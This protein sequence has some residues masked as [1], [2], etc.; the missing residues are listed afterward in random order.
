MNKILKE[1]SMFIFS[2]VE[3]ILVFRFILK[4]LGA[5]SNSSFVEFIYQN[6]QPLLSPFL[7]A[8]PSPSVRGRFILEFTTLFAVFVYAFVGYLFQE[9]LDFINK[10]NK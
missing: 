3:I 1:F 2:L 7:L 10:K 4:F 9:I 5:S 6:T 8:F